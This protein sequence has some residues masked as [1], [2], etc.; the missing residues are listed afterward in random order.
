ME[1]YNGT[2]E[3]YMLVL[4]NKLQL[5][6]TLNEYISTLKISSEDKEYY[7]T[8]V[9]EYCE[10]DFRMY[11][12]KN[13][14]LDILKFGELTEKQKFKQIDEYYDLGIVTGFIDKFNGEDKFKKHMKLLYDYTIQN[15]LNK[16]TNYI[17]STLTYHEF[18]YKMEYKKQKIEIFL[19]HNGRN[20]LPYCVLANYEKQIFNILFRVFALMTTGNNNKIIFPEETFYCFD[21]D[22]KEFI[23]DVLNKY[24]N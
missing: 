7:E 2:N 4:N 12:F 11:R 19:E 18:I 20:E 14:P 6:D 15:L 3:I 1:Q 21:E 23:M 5:R 8:L 9:D 16:I 10:N 13:R 17:N 24:N 22:N